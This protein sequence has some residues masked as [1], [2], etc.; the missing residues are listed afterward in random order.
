M[1]PCRFIV[2]LDLLV[3]NS[4]IGVINVLDWVEQPRETTHSYP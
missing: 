1:E 2:N 3:Y 4:T